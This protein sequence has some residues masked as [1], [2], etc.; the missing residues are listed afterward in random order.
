M[1]NI[2]GLKTVIRDLHGCDS[3]HVQSVPVRETTQE[4]VVWEGDVEVFL[5]VD[6]RRVKRAYVWSYTNNFGQLRHMVVLGLPPINSAVDTVRASLG[7]ES[8]QTMKS[9]D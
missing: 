3:I 5:L 8:Q 6:H 4:N 7:I 9:D 1:K 2:E